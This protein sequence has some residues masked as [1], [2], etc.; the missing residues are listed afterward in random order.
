MSATTT[1]QLASAIHQG[2]AWLPPLAATQLEFNLPKEIE[3]LH[4]EAAWQGEAGRSS[5]TLVKHPDLRIVLIAMKAHKFMKE[6]HAAGRI[7][8]QTLTGHI[9]LH[10]PHGAVDLPAG[11]LLVLDRAMRHDVEAVEE[12]A[13]LLT[14][15][16]PV[17][18]QDSH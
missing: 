6:H 3:L 2:H 12:S 9:R 15:S 16:W 18:G 8:V 1:S 5:K 11:R 7:S 4:R 14:I 13:F 10:L 17:D